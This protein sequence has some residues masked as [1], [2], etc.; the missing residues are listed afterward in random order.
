M[1]KKTSI[2]FLF[3]LSIV[4][5]KLFSQDYITQNFRFKTFKE[6]EKWGFK[7]DDKIVIPASFDYVTDFSENLALV[8]TNGKWGYIDTL[9]N[10][11]IQAMYDK[12]QPMQ[13]GR[14]FVQKGNLIGLIE[15]QYGNFLLEPIYTNIKEDYNAYYVYDGK[16]MGYL[17]KENLLDIHD[18]VIPAKYD[19]IVN[20]YGLISG[21]NEDKTWDIYQ[22]GKLIIEKASKHIDYNDYDYA[23]KLVKIKID[24]KTGVYNLGFENPDQA[25]VVK[26]AYEWIE[27]L[28]F[29]TYTLKGQSSEFNMIFALHENDLR[30]INMEVWNY[31]EPLPIDLIVLAKADGSLISKEKFNAVSLLY[32]L[33]SEIPNSFAIQMYRDSKLV[34]IYPDFKVEKLKYSNLISHYYNKWFI[35]DGGNVKY[36][37]DADYN[38]LDSFP[39]VRIYQEF[40]YYPEGGYYDE[41]GE[42]YYTDDISQTA[43]DV[44]EPFLIAIRYGDNQVEEKAIYQLEERKII[45]P[46]LA[47]GNNELKIERTPIDFY[48]TTLYKYSL[49]DTLG[50]YVKGMDKGTRMTFFNDYIL[51]SMGSFF[52]L[53]T[54]TNDSEFKTSL[55]QYE[56]NKDISLNGK[57]VDLSKVKLISDEFEIINSSE[58][59][60]YGLKRDFDT[61]EIVIDPETGGEMYESIPAFKEYFLILKDKQNKY[62]LISA[63]NVYVAPK[64]DTLYQNSTYPNFV[65]LVNKDSSGYELFGNVNLYHGEIIEPFSSQEI[66]FLDFTYLFRPYYYSL[67]FN[68]NENA[69]NYFNLK[70]EKFYNNPEFVFPKKV[71][72]KYG[73]YAFPFE[74]KQFNNPFCQVE[75]KYRNLE[76]TNYTGIFKAQGKNKKWGLINF[77]GDTLIPL[78]YSKFEIF[79]VDPENNFSFYTFQKNKVGVYDIYKG[80]ILPCKFDNISTYSSGDYFSGMYLTENDKKFGLL[81][82]TG[83][84]ILPPVYD[85]ITSHFSFNGENDATEE[86]FV[87]HKG[88]KKVVYYFNQNTELISDVSKLKEYD[89]INDHFGYIRT[90]S[91][92]DVYYLPTNTLQETIPLDEL[93]LNGNQYSI[94]IQNG[95]FGAKDASGNITVPCEY[96]FATFFEGRDEVMIG[97]QNGVKYYIYVENNERF[98]EQQW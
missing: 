32:D 94:I 7:K 25:W 36:I 51:P 45:S 81:S 11:H 95:K 64:Y 12:G 18:A 83:I 23:S 28:A 77:L 48:S 70:G 1:N 21:R 69:Y 75:A 62:G 73:L 26:P 89:F 46:W 30:D 38:V 14:A 47:D 72:K 22:N 53:R 80:E 6:G 4:S 54:R 57:T 15:A 42:F 56:K 37:L 44:N 40:S 35:A 43:T 92:F 91:S 19:S 2:L 63:L 82:P 76:H 55:F 96:D 84:E 39:D 74:Y 86:F 52:A 90:S 85:E 9:G 88:S 34:N 16:K 31:D 67:E 79:E 97:Y 71:K 61:H 29:P 24:D 5:Q 17:N 93:Q 10:W 78:K 13:E 20:Q 68:E 66:S 65:S 3:L 33:Y 8:K 27:F 59:F 60:N 58:I 98:T 87:G 49:G 50:Y 41:N